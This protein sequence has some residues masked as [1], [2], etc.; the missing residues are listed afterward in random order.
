MASELN[1]I[2]PLRGDRLLLTDK[3]TGVTHTHLAYLR[4]I[5]DQY[6][7]SY[8]YSPLALQ[9]SLEILIKFFLKLYMSICHHGWG[10]F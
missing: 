1:A 5:K 7:L 3:Y 8:F 9:L 10:T 4:R 6:I 2:E